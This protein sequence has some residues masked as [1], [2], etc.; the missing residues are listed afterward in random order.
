MP[1]ALEEAQA[2]KYLAEAR[3]ADAEARR[4]EFEVLTA[5]NINQA[6]TLELEQKVIQH[7][8][9]LAS[10]TD[11]TIYFLGEVSEMS[12]SRAMDSFT[13][14]SR[15]DPGCD[16]D[17]II[18]SPG[19]LIAEGMALFDHIQTIKRKGCVVNTIVL[20]EAASMGGVLLQ[21]GTNRIM[22]K[23]SWLMLHEAAFGGRGKTSEIEDRVEYVKRVQER[24]LD[25][26]ASR[27][28]MTKRQIQNKWTRKDWWL[29]SEDAL[30]AGF[31]DEVR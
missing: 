20:G 2:Q 13:E 27:S 15:I 6:S 12:V 21:A 14:Y 1:T 10:K 11:R 30:E 3:K 26:Y 16:I 4:A 31:I 28:N 5:Q 8:S 25:I 24:I 17:F 23:E 7:K 18:N 22:S 9:W 19:G 29:S